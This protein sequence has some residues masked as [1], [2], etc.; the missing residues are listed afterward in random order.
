MNLDAVLTIQPSW[1]SFFTGE[2]VTFKC[3]MNKGKD[4]KWEYKINK[5][6][7]EFIQYNTLKNYRLEIRSTGDSGE[8][9]CSG[10]TKSSHKPKHSN[11]V[12]LTVLGKSSVKK[13]AIHLNTNLDDKIQCTFD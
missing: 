4:S 12:S 13:Q 8:Y 1:S 5:N 2:F 10:R 3:N 6:G 9:Q 7:R 11:T